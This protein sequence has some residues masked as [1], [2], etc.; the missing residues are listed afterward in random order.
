ME[1]RNPNDVNCKV[2]VVFAQKCIIRKKCRVILVKDVKP[3][4][5]E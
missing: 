1:I 3:F 5:E 4:F 2:N